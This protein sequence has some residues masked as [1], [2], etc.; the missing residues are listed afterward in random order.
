[1][2]GYGVC[3]ER[4]IL[5][6]WGLDKDLF[7]PLDRGVCRERLGLDAAAFVVLSP[8]I[9]RRLYN[10]HIIIRAMALFLQREPAAVLVIC[11]FLADPAYRQSLHA[12]CAEL[13]V[14]QRVIWKT[15]VARED[16]P[17]LYSAADVVVGIPESD[18]MPMTVIEAM[19]CGAV[20]VVGPL[21][22]YAELFGDRENVLY[23][24]PTAAALAHAL[25][26]LLRDGALRKRLRI[27]GERTVAKQPTLREDAAALAAR[28]RAL[29]AR[30]RRRQPAL[31]RCHAL[32]LILGDFVL[33]VVG[34]GLGCTRKK[35]ARA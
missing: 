34:R 15:A 31:V 26:L 4:V 10:Q 21:P 3:P 28:M 27:A 23:T 14:E 33:S 17:V 12:L 30:P 1:M 25:E 13:G 7:R 2:L 22:H 18:G 35:F 5:L 20:N 16:M 24:Q 6:R 29:I 8:R 19:A 32:L 11:D 9:V